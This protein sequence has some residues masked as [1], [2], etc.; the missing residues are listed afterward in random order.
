MAKGRSVYE[1]RV[2]DV[3]AAKQSIETWLTANKFKPV[4][5]KGET[6]YLSKSLWSGNKYFNYIIDGNTIT[7]E[8]FAHGIAGDFDLD[9][10]T[11]QTVAKPF[12]EKLRPLF[13]E[14]KANQ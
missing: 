14:L 1:F 6:V 2:K 10:E 12:R 11:V 13:D 8:A 7:I 3:N 4:S 5:L 9:T